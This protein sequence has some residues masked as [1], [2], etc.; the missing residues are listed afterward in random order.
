MKNVLRVILLV[1]ITTLSCE[2][3]VSTKFFPPIFERNGV[4]TLPYVAGCDI[5]RRSVEIDPFFHIWNIKIVFSH[6]MD[7]VSVE[8]NTGV[9]I[10]KGLKDGT[11]LLGD[12]MPVEKITWDYDNTVMIYT[13]KLTWGKKF[14]L[15]ISKDAKDVFGNQLDGRVSFGCRKDDDFKNEP[16]DFYSVPF[17]VGGTEDVKGLE[18]GTQTPWGGITYSPFIEEIHILHFYS[19]KGAP[20]DEDFLSMDALYGKGIVLYP[21]STSFYVKFRVPS[22][23]KIDPLT[24]SISLAEYPDGWTIPLQFYDEDS[25]IWT[26]VHNLSP[27]KEVW[28]RPATYLTPS[29]IYAFEVKFAKDLYNI[30]FTDGREDEDDIYRIFITSSY[31]PSTPTIPPS[32]L[33]IPWCDKDYLC[34]AIPSGGL[35]HYI[36]EDTLLPSYTYGTVFISIP[37]GVPVQRTAVYDPQNSIIF[38]SVIKDLSGRYLDTD[39]DGVE[40]GIFRSY[41]QSKKI[42]FLKMEDEPNDTF[43]QAFPL[44]GTCPTISAT[45]PAWDTDFYSFELEA[46][47]TVQIFTQSDEFHHVNTAI[48]LYSEDGNLISQDLDSGE[49]ISVCQEYC[50]AGLSLTLDPGLFY[51]EVYPQYP[52][53]WNEYNPPTYILSF[54][55]R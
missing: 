34:F 28:V 31:K 41:I 4:R 50:D 38:T 55:I 15:K 13:V 11:D 16:A 46:T 10:L 17:E 45:I 30:S 49:L 12:K 8:E 6:R 26:D 25:G 33:V 23:S 32:V 9:Y 22:G 54:C 29:T 19:W 27:L 20:K 1:L 42:P 24:L 43:L 53:L 36:D 48:R 18:D 44:D 51:I 47:S 35:F 21:E 52:P 39:A 7:T 40:G 2:N 14:V 37:G 3:T 5:E